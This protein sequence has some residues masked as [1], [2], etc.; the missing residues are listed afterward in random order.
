MNKF[1]LTRQFTHL[2]NSFYCSDTIRYTLLSHGEI[3]PWLQVLI[4]PETNTVHVQNTKHIL[5]I[6]NWKEQLNTARVKIR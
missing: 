5:H 4:T 6:S 2:F 1:L 3:C